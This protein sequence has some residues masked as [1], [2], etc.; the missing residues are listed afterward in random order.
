M[1]LQVKRI[2]SISGRVF[3]IFLFLEF[4]FFDT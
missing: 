1:Y 3:F 2:L 4:L